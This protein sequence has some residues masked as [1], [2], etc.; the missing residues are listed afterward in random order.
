M[1]ELC[2]SV[3]FDSYLLNSYQAALWH[4]NMII[5]IRSRDHVVISGFVQKPT[6]IILKYFFVYSDPL[7]LY[8]VITLIPF[9]TA[10]IFFT[11]CTPPILFTTAEVVITTPCIPFLKVNKK[12]LDTAQ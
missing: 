6:R 5:L 10:M 4:L 9:L 1:L 7:S 2:V 3:N 11:K 8:T 12:I